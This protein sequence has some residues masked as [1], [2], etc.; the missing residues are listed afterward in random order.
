MIETIRHVINEK[1]GD[2]VVHV[3]RIEYEFSDDVSDEAKD[4]VRNHVP[5]LRSK[6]DVRR[7]IESV[8]SET[9]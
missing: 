8:E 4:A 2:D 9:E 3:N 6:D 5:K 7:V 1:Q